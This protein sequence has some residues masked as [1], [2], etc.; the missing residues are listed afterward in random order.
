MCAPGAAKP[1]G[2]LALGLTPSSRCSCARIL[3]GISPCPTLAL[4]H[5]PPP[6]GGA[7]ECHVAPGQVCS[8]T[9]LGQASPVGP[10]GAY[11]PTASPGGGVSLAKWRLVP[12]L[13]PVSLDLLDQGWGFQPHSLSAGPACPV[14][15][16]P[17]GMLPSQQP[18]LP[19][20]K[21]HLL[22]SSSHGLV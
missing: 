20:E 5:I 21:S 6:T 3:G 2:R 14:R 9:A 16:L 11:V 13:P 4:G 19:S 7:S 1:P 10:A 8:G 22:G 18:F 17:M 12:L 15:L